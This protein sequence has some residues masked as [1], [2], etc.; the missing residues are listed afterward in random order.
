MFALLLTLLA[1]PPDLPVVPPGDAGFDARTLQR[2]DAVVAEGLADGDLSGCVVCVGHGGKIGWLKAYGN[3]SEQPAT[4]P[5]TTD[6]VFDL[7]SITKPV[8]T[9]SSVLHLHQAGRLRLGDKVSEHLPEFTGQGKEDVTVIQ[10][11]THTGGL[12][13]DNSIDDYADGPELARKRIMDLDLKSQPGEKFAY[14]D[15]GFIVLG[16]LVE[17]LSGMPLDEYAA[18]NLYEPLGMEKTGYKPDQSLRNRAETTEQREGRWMRGEV[19]D[20]R[21]FALGG[22]AGHAGLFSTAEDLAVYAQLLLNGGEHQGTRIFSEST[23]ALMSRRF[24]IPRQ[25]YLK[26]GPGYR[27]AGWDSDSPYSTNR[28]DTFSASAFGHGGFTGTSLWLDPEHD[29]FVIFLGNRLHPDGKGYVNDLCGRVGNVAVAALTDANA[30]Q[31]REPVVQASRVGRDATPWSPVELPHEEIATSQREL[32]AGKRVGLITNHTG[33]T[34][35][36]RRIVDVLAEAEDVKL[37]KLFSPEHGWVGGLDQSEIG[38]TADEKTGLP[39]I[40]LY[41]ANRK[42]TPAMLDGLDVLVFDIQDIG[43]RFY[44]YIS[45]MGLA[46]QAAAEADIP[47]L[48]LDRPNPIGRI[49]EGPLRDEDAGSF[50]AYHDIPVRHGMT[51]AELALMIRGERVPDLDLHTA[52]ISGWKPQT[53]FDSTGLTWTDPS[54]NMRSLAQAVLYPGI[55]LVEYTNLSVGRGTDTPFEV[56]G[57]PWI[58]GRTLA[59]ALNGLELPGATFVPV[60]FTPDASKF[61]GEACGGVNI[62]VTDRAAFASVPTGLALAHTL[63][64]LYPQQW[65]VDK[66]AQLL[67][68]ADSLRMIKATEPLDEL[69]AHCAAEAAKFRQRRKPYLIYPENVGGDRMS[70]VVPARP[71]GQNRPG[72]DPPG[73]DRP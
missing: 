17:K 19:H 14:T 38:D 50:V 3:R 46:M 10:L 32:L 69:L 33:L 55:G 11:L 57:A 36:G 34:G 24:P 23:V 72:Q 12:I 67:A 61:A 4:E 42:P 53:Y 59:A 31:R 60:R 16:Y 2:I 58:D 21:A 51:V 56:V 26:T 73:Q 66:L 44:T 41:G 39:V 48:V 68:D 13:P 64:R 43:C 37:A 54:P 35:S 62:A 20:P 28:A 6:T 22:V 45:T 71:T 8:A 27:T 9:A 49:V 1:A 30:P 52:A 18:K 70:R 65:E 40:S 63:R 5:M 15:V 25:N 29:L 7:A 47:F